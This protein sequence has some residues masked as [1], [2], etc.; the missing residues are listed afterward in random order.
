MGISSVNAWGPGDRATF[1]ED[2]PAGYLTFNSI[3]NDSNYGD[4][5]NFVLVK[6]AVNTQAGGFVDMLNVEDDHMYLVRVF[7]HNNAAENLNLVA[8]NVRLSVGITTG[9][10]NN[11]E[12]EV[13]LNSSNAD[14]K[15]IWDEVNLKANSEFQIAYVSNSAQYYTNANGSST[16]ALGNEIVTS[17]DGVLL[18]YDKLD[19]RI[20]GCYQYTGIATFKV[21]V[22]FAKDTSS[23]ALPPASAAPTASAVLVNGKSVAFDA[24]NISGNN[25]FKLRDLAFTLNGTEKQFAVGWDGAANAIA[26]TSGR[27]YTAIGGE[28]EGKGAGNKTAAPTT[29]KITLDGKDV[30]L[31][32]YNIGGNNYF[33]L[34]DV[35]QTFNFGVDW[36]GASNT[37]VINTGKSYTSE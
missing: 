11:G 26:L 23:S 35:A 8:E 21:K 4:E 6:D 34:R 33:K 37:I 5:R 15:E 16:F 10:T 14:P 9:L 29:S 2:K 25:Y 1:T 12:I 31:D 18:G 3:T 24:Y 19:G 30:S 36:D 22:N 17:K 20:P 28:M 13:R 27:S 7:V 32:A